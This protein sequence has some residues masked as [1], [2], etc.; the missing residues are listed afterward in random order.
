M[1][2]YESPSENP[3]YKRRLK[4]LEEMKEANYGVVITGYTTP[5]ADSDKIYYMFTDNRPDGI[6]VK[7]AAIN[8]C[9]FKVVFL[10]NEDELIQIEFNKF[11][12]YMK[13]LT[14]ICP[15]IKFKKIKIFELGEGEMI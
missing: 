2:E 4:K 11:L 9:M 7:T 15:S 6:T 12:G 3:E 13:K 14:H 1:T 5:D 10:V 8:K